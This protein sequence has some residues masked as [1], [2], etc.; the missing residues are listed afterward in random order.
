MKNMVI[1]V[2]DQNVISFDCYIEK[3]YIYIA[4]TNYFRKSDIITED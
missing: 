1:T 2:L 4:N 3:D